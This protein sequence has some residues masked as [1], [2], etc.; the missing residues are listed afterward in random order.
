MKQFAMGAATTLGLVVGAVA[1]VGLVGFAG[2][3]GRGHGHGFA[4]D[5]ARMAAFVTDRV[6]DL[7]DD[8]DATPD[9]R[10]RIHAVKDRLLETAQKTRAGREEAHAAIHE[11]WKAEQ[12]DAARLHALVDQRIEEMRALAHQAV[13]GG[14][15][16][17]G[18]LTPEQREKLSR[19]AER[20][21]R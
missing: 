18:I 9:Q 15:E 4:R 12:P 19:K 17:H 16:V 13:D 8:V 1:L 7:L 2:G 6:D 3:C 5:P 21:H 14:V 11:E 10:T 20:W